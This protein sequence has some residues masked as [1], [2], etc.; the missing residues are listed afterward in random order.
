MTYEQTV[1]DL[2][3]I[4]TEL[5]ELE[6]VERVHSNADEPDGLAL[7]ILTRSPAK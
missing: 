7:E 4:F 3:Y 2:K 6:S 5:P 1:R